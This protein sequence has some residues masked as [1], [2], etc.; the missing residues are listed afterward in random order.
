MIINHFEFKEINKTFFRRAW[1]FSFMK[2]H[3]NYKGIYKKDGT[4]EWGEQGYNG[5]DRGEVEKQI[6]ALMDYHVYS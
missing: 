3:R 2:D 1:Q 4:I 5:D 6:H